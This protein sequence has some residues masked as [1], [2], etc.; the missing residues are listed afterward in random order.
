MQTGDTDVPSFKDR[1]AHFRGGERRL[2]GDRDVGRPGTEDSN[3]TAPT[4]TLDL[5]SGCDKGAGNW[6]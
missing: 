4:W 2:G 3:N 1:C 6:M 5:G